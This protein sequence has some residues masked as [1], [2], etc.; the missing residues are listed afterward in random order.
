MK[1]VDEYRVVC[2]TTPGRGDSTLVWHDSWNGIVQASEFPRLH[3]FALDSQ[4]SV[5]EVV[6][7]S[8]RATLFYMPLSQQAFEEFNSLELLVNSVVLDHTKKDKW[9]T[10]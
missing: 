5:Q 1:L 4:I 3:S 9:V 7:C 10:I 6:S 8:D 2:T